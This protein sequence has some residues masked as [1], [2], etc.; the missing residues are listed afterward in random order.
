M[1]AE[2]VSSYRHTGYDFPGS[3]GLPPQPA[4]GNPDLHHILAG[5]STSNM[6]EVNVAM[7]TAA[8]N[9]DGGVYCLAVVLM[10]WHHNVKLSPFEP[11]HSVLDPTLLAEAAWRGRRPRSM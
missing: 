8:N 9:T 10:Q 5:Y 1:G 11:A 2:S 3:A 4:L 7:F 6:D